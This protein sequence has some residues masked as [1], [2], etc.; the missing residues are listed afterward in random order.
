MAKTWFITGASRGIGA[1]IV[2]A[3]L[4]AGNNVVATARSV[5]KITRPTEV[6]DNL[7]AV[8][9]DVTQEDQVNAAVKAAVTKFG[10][11]DVLINNAGYGH[12]GVFEETTPEEVRA[13]FNTNVFGLMDVTRAV[14]PFMRKQGGGRIFNISSIA[15]LKGIFGGS[16]YNSSKFAVEGFSQSIAEELAP[17][18]IFVTCI[19]P[20]FFRTDFLDPSSVKYSKRSISDYDRAMNDYRNFL[21]NRCYNQ[22]GDP[23]KLAKLVL[24]L[25]EIENPPVS[26]VAGSDAI[27]WAKSAIKQK[28]MEL[29]V[30]RDY[31]VSTDGSW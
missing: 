9:L 7:L 14:I 17:Y 21:D 23:T 12:F 29:D 5:D 16:L 30:W 19:S 25:V 24:Q 18:K 27:E 22:L 1:E 28:Q 2:K 15:G 8:K 3:A 13:E 11:I 31:S 26:L 4:K 6:S 10:R 20:G